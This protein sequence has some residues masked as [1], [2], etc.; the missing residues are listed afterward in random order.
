MIIRMSKM[1][2]RSGMTMAEMLIVVAIIAVL[3]G[4]AFVAVWNYQRSM[5]QLERDGIAKEIFVAAQNHLTAA[6]GEGYLG[7]TYFGRNGEVAEDT[8]KE[9]Y[10]FT[11]NGIISD[12]SALSLMLPF[13]SID[14][15]VRKGGSYIIRYQKSTGLVLDVF[16]CTKSGS[17]DN[18]NYELKESDYTTVLGLRDIENKNFKQDRRN[19]N[20][21]IL[22]WYGGVEAAS[23]PKTTLLAPSITVHNEEKLY[24][25]IT[26]PNTSVKDSDGN[27]V[28]VSVRLLIKGLSSGTE[29]YINVTDDSQPIILD[30]ITTSNRHFT[31]RRFD[32]MTINE[33]DNGFIPGENI[34]IRA[35]AYCN[36][37]FANVAYSAKS[38]TN[39]LF[40]GI[41]S[42]NDTAYIGNIRHLE[43]L[44]NTVSNLDANDGT[45]DNDKIRLSHAEQINS[46]SWTDFQK[47]IRIIESKSETDP[48]E[49]TGYEAVGVYRCDGTS[50]VVE[51][52]ESNYIGYYMPIEPSYE[53]KYDGQNYSISD[54]AV[55]ATGDATGYAGLF[56]ATSSVTAISNLELI[57]FSI[58]GTTSA[59][60][61]AGTLTNCTV[62]NVLARNKDNSATSLTKKITATGDAGG[63]IG[64][65]TNGTVQYSA[66]VVIVNGSTTAG[67]LIGSAGGEIIGCYSGGHTKSGSYEKW[68]ELNP[69]DVT[70]DTAG[71]LVGSSSAKIS[72]SYSTCS[73]SGTSY[74]GGF[75]GNASESITNCYA[76]GYIQTRD[77]AATYAFLASGSANLVGNY[78]YRAINE[79]Q[80]TTNGKTVTEPMEPY[81]NAGEVSNHLNKTKPLDL[82]AESYNEFVGIFESNE[83]SEEDGWNPARAYDPA[84]VQYYSGKYT[85]QT[86]DELNPSATLPTGTTWADLFVTTHYGDWPSPEVFF[87]NE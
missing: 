64:I 32:D 60:A 35:V 50:T 61:L 17:P 11:V 72:D 12:A 41:N 68:I 56:G 73:V 67:G 44:D 54:V 6:Y 74:A 39:S 1:K 29:H 22:G 63:L 75:A 42:T 81:P 80:K 9:V 24:V 46:F 2:N 47:A 86:V 34:E 26:N 49:G 23:I 28:T 5:G 20:K 82:N 36:D 31:N 66:A 83:E 14:E 87:I 19:W 21:H 33:E 8:G 16:Y 48:G 27:N 25:E 55:D 51:E 3:G 13:G 4:V 40:A 58:T 85:L 71:G 70:G 57:D 45:D 65:L 76:T 59:G 43:N 37:V 78:Y 79:K 52:G 69:F 62:T 53:L 38:V 7:T 84:L 77:D 18:F 15:T 10:Y 30:D